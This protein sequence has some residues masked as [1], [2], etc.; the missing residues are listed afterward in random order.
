MEFASVEDRDYFITADPVH[1]DYARRCHAL[2][3]NGGFI[4]FTHGEM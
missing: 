4:D 3:D 1:V 2:L